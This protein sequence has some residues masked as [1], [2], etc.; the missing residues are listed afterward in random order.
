MAGKALVFPEGI[1][2]SADSRP[3]QNRIFEPLHEGY[4]FSRSKKLL[5]HGVPGLAAELGAFERLAVAAMSNPP[6]A[7]EIRYSAGEIPHLGEGAFHQGAEAEGLCQD[8][9]RVLGERN[10]Q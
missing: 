8:P 5:C 1:E 6:G 10:G 7:E 2:D 9:G 4:F 3:V